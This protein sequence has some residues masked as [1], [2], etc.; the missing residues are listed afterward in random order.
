MRNYGLIGKKLSYS[1][2]K[3]YFTEKFEREGI[4]NAAFHLYELPQVADFIDL[5]KRT[6]SLRGVTV[7]I[8]YK[9]EI[10][11]YLH[12]ID[13]VAQRVGAVNVVKIHPDG[14]LT[15]HNSDYYG[16]KISL[17]RFLQGNTQGLR[18]LVL[19]T[20]GASRAVSTVLQDLN[21]PFV[22]VS[23]T[24]TA[25]QL[26]YG[27]LNEIDLNDFRLIINTTPL[28]TFPQVG[29]CP[30][31]PYHR[32]TP[33]HYLHDLVYNPENTA[34]MQH[35]AAQGAQVKSGLE[36]LHQQAEKAWEIWNKNE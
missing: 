29:E 22:L 34:F 30:P 1:F 25:Q 4:A 28:G 19:G 14:R 13:E 15:G 26:S 9:L 7:T 12:H 31:L 10:M 2:S 16:F 27:Q 18:A 23:R 33:A 17:E 36:M 20:G 11:P 5:A 32:L 8:P 24:A 3:K 35:G 6:P 21:I